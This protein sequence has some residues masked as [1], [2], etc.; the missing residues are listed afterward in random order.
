MLQS[1]LQRDF[2]LFGLILRR[3]TWDQ[4]QV[5]TIH[6]TASVKFSYHHSHEMTPANLTVKN[7][8][9]TVILRMHSAADL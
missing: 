8:F 3:L 1:N 7:S 9:S 2:F 5:F 6:I 4:Q